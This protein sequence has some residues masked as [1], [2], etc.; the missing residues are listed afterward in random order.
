MAERYMPLKEFL[1]VLNNVS[2]RP[3]LITFCAL[4]MTTWFSNDALRTPTISWD[5]LFLPI[6]VFSAYVFVWGWMYLVL[7]LNSRLADND[8]FSWGPVIGC[9][10]LALCIRIAFS[11]LSSHPQGL[12][13]ALLGEPN[14]IHFCTLFLLAAQTLKI[15]RH[16]E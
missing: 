6:L 14:F 2:T 4:S 3:L 10:L 13:F 1:E 11:H 5:L 16:R 12:T 8:L 9:T 15:R 7:T